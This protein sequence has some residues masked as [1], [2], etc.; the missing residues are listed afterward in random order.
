MTPIAIA[1]ACVFVAITIYAITIVLGNVI[2]TIK[3]LIPL[4]I[5]AL[6]LVIW[7]HSQNIKI[8]FLI[9]NLPSILKKIIQGIS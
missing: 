1:S 5:V 4:S 7:T 2:S 3:D 9:E 6:L 8:V